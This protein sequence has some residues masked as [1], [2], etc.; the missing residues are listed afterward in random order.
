MRIRTKLMAGFVIIV[1]SSGIAGLAV[2]SSAER[3]KHTQAEA[4]HSELQLDKA[5]AVATALDACATAAVWVAVGAADPTE[6]RSACRFFD[7]QTGAGAPRAQEKATQ[8]DDGPDEGEEQQSSR[9]SGLVARVAWINLRLEN[10]AE[11]GPGAPGDIAGIIRSAEYRAVRS[12]A[13]TAVN[14]E[15]AELEEGQI[16]ARSA[17]TA[18]SKAGW[19]IGIGNL[20]VSLAVLLWI[21][22]GFIRS[23]G[24]LLV[25]TGRIAAG[26]LGS[27]TGVTGADEL[28]ELGS[29]FDRMAEAL[30]QSLE[31]QRCAEIVSRGLS[32]QAGKAEMA[33]GVLHNV[34]NALNGLTV[35]TGLLVDGARG[36]K[37]KKLADTLE[38]LRQRDVE[39]GGALANDDRGGKI[40]TFLGK[41]AER[42]SVENGNTLRQGQELE[43][44][45]HHIAAV[46][47]RQQE[48]AKPITTVDPR[49]PSDV[50][51]DATNVLR[52][53]FERHS[54]EL[55]ER[56]EFNEIIP[57]D[58]D[59]L[60]Q[61][62]VNLIRNAKDSAVAK[63][64]A[65]MRVEVATMVEADKIKIS[66]SDNGMGVSDE[67]MG[68]LF[69]HGFTTKPD[70]HG[71]GL[72]NSALLAEELGGRLRCESDGPGRGATF[73]LELPRPIIILRD[74][75]SATGLPASRVTRGS[76][77]VKTLVGAAIAPST[78]SSRSPAYRTSTR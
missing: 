31:R 15:K 38:L 44:A 43:K 56:Y 19:A 45:T 77:R 23:L 29:S 7:G 76:G 72:H 8:S 64:T 63:A 21:L 12:A 33:A 20:L 78:G 41:L 11:S 52:S 74:A 18:M 5:N 68:K 59:R 69:R 75:R 54:I 32:R 62:V 9:L 22:P 4:L 28:A 3:V 27:R 26:E 66:V 25:A 16:A 51:K 40:V 49:N 65:G 34:G 37:A 17:M 30:E 53:S 35:G 42:W 60:L 39:L 6:V 50:V 46:V 47:A 48:Y 55:V 61:I 13:A 1:V 67:D 71:F 24:Q 57:V 36:S 58:A 70:G 73:I 10:A 2:T 14:E